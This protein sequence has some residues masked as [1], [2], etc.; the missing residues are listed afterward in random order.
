MRD[1]IASVESSL[2]AA[3]ERQ[4]SPTSVVSDAGSLTD[5]DV[6]HGPWHH[7]LAGRSVSPGGPVSLEM[8][9]I[10]KSD[11][12]ESDCTPHLIARFSWTRPGAARRCRARAAD[13]S[14]DGAILR[15]ASRRGGE[16]RARLYCRVAPQLTH[17]TLDSGARA[18]ES[19]R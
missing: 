4:G 5:D 2:H 10:K 7:F 8:I 14:D 15:A 11:P 9:R 18:S 16:T 3:R 6:R 12:Q 1:A 19:G 17:F 13:A